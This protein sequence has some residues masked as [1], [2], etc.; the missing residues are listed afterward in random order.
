MAAAIGL[1]GYGLRVPHYGELLVRGTRCRFVEAITENFAGRGG[2][3]HAVLERVR[4]D[5]EVALHGVS[6][7]L[8]G[9]DPLNE[10]YLDQLDAL[11]RAVQPIFVSDHLCF[12]TVHGWSGHDL[13]PLPYTEEALAHVVERIKRVQDRL[14]RRILVENVSSYLEHTGSTLTEHAFLCEVAQRA[15]CSILLDVNNVIVSAKNHGVDP[16]AYIAALPVER[17]AQLHLAGHTDYGTHAIDD[18]GSAVPPE[19]WALHRTVVERFG[20]V[21]AIVEWDQN[22]PALEVLEAEASRA[23]IRAERCA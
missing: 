12:G 2:R 22:L 20:D 4:R 21:P 17:V 8:G 5:A 13:W 23:R 10:R 19:V 6:L 18:H 9:V 16:D 11:Q 15:D 7:S 3:A 14:R 1:H